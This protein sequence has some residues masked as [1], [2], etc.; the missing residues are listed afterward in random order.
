MCV[1]IRQNLRAK[2][3]ARMIK[4]LTRGFQ[5]GPDQVLVVERL[6]VVVLRGCAMLALWSVNFSRYGHQQI[7][8]WWTVSCAFSLSLW[9]G[10]EFICLKPFGS[11]ISN[12]ICELRAQC[13]LWWMLWCKTE[14]EW[15][16]RLLF[17]C[18]S[19]DS[20][21]FI[22]LLYTS[23]SAAGRRRSCSS[24]RFSWAVHFFLVHATLAPV[25]V[26]RNHNRSWLFV[27][28]FNLSWDLWIWQLV[29]RSV[30]RTKCSAM[31]CGVFCNESPCSHQRLIHRSHHTTTQTTTNMKRLRWGGGR[32]RRLTAGRSSSL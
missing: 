6:Y 32:V 16:T 18:L 29:T 14:V 13:S 23:T 31:S 26:S 27:L 2:F 22:H 19:L 24:V 30:L 17:T 15:K 3:N 4:N 12:P 25:H 11:L 20:T 5:V 8:V 7:L 1:L 9:F 10:L 28:H 21:A